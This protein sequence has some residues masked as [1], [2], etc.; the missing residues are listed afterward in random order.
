MKKRYCFVVFSNPTPHREDEYNTWYSEV[1]LPHVLAVPGFVSA[2]RLKVADGSGID[3]TPLPGRYMALYEMETD[4]PAGALNEMWSRAG[5]PAMTISE[6]IDGPNST[7]TLFAAITGDV[8][9]A[10]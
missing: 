8:F 1:H 3:N 9:P 10:E 5:T 2:R 4:N 6:A 7:H